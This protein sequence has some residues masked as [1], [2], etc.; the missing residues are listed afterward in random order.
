MCDDWSRENAGGGRFQEFTFANSIESA[1]TSQ[2]TL[3]CSFDP[4]PLTNLPGE[5]KA[6]SGFSEDIA[7]AQANSIVTAPIKLSLEAGKVGHTS[8][9]IADRVDLML[10]D[11]GSSETSELAYLCNVSPE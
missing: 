5:T 9:S 2:I 10:V 11:L 7:K 8:V 3:L 1:F 4:A 6:C